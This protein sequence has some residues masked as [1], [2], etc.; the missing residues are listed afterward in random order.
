MQQAIF[1]RSARCSFRIDNRHKAQT[2][3]LSV[4]HCLWLQFKQIVAH[5]EKLA[6]EMH[7]MHSRL[8]GELLGGVQIESKSGHALTGSSL[9]RVRDAPVHRKERH[10]L[11]DQQSTGKP[12]SSR[13]P[14]TSYKAPLRAAPSQEG[15]PATLPALMIG[16]C[17]AEIPLDSPSM[18]NAHG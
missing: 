8:V 10:S 6:D 16:S 12:V 13:H 1:S 4:S 7:D 2:P 17:A 14:P 11:L 9:T 3:L 15:K 5:R 18:A